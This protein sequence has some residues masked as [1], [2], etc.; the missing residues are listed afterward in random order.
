MEVVSPAHILVVDDNPDITDLVALIL[1]EQGHRV[2]AAF[3]GEEAVRKAQADPADL[4][5]LDVDMDGL[6]GHATAAALRADVR[7]RE[8][9]ML[10]VT[11]N[12]DLES[13]LRALREGAN[14]YITKPFH[15]E[16]LLAR[17]G[18]A[19]RIKALQDALRERNER[20]AQMAV[21]DELTGLANRR[22]VL[23]RLDQEVSRARRYRLALSCL[24]LDL[25]TSSG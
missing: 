21:V 6:D 4:V 12:T 10:F 20:L 8:A 24:M 14:D 15:R 1:T 18:V 11:G 13:K 16:E 9:P 25:T 3:S 2:T 17:V 23:Q 19:L 5:L 7:M 22:F